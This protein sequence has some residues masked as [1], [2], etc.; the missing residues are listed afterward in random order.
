MAFAREAPRATAE[1]SRPGIASELGRAHSDLLGELQQSNCRLEQFAYAA[2]HDLQEPLRQMSAFCQLLHQQYAPAL[3]EQAKQ[4]LNFVVDGATRMQA[5]VKGLLEYARVG[6]RGQ[7]LALTS[8]EQ[9][10]QEACANLQVAISE[11]GAQITHDCLP[12]VLADSTQLVQLLQNLVGNAIKY[13]GDRTPA[14]HVSATCDEDA[15]TFSVR[16]NGI[17]IAKE[18]HERVFVIFQ[19]LHTA[20][21]YP[22]TGLGLALCHLI[23]ERL[24]GRIWVES[25]PQRGSTFCFTLPRL[26]T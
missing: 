4:Y 25:E 14:V 24:G 20:D 23:V 13:R 2:A 19:R 6:S 22:G 8:S 16:D 26:A 12:V 21:Q 10:L 17:G 15:W 18:F 1:T 5:L 7:P 11:S 9:V 3:D